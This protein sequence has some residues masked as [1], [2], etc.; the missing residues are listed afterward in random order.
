MAKQFLT[1]LNLNKNELQNIVL[2]PLATAPSSPSNGQMY[3][4]T[5]DKL[6]YVYAYDAWKAVGSVL[7][8]NGK[9]GVVVLTQDDVGDGTTYVRTHNDLT[10]ALK[11][12]YATGIASHAPAYDSTATYAKGDRCTYEGQ[13]YI[14]KDAISTAEDWTASHWTATTESAQLDLKLDLAGGTMSGAIAMGNNKI[15]GLA[16]PTADGDAANK[17]YV[18]DAFAANDAMIFKGTI[19]AAADTPTITAL[20]DTHEAG[21]TYRVVTAGTYASKTCEVGD[22]IICVKDGTTASDGD[23]TVAQTNIDGAVTGPASAVSGHVPTFNGTSGKVIQDGYAVVTSI[24]DDDTSLPTAGAVYDEVGGF[25]KV[26]TGTIST[27]ATT[28]DVTYTDGTVINAYAKMGNDE[29]VLDITY[30]AGKVTF[31]CAQ[32]PSAAVTC[33]V[34]HTARALS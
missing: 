15:T 10:D 3:Y 24:S 23:W 4:N 17:K 25:I 11:T 21:W 5:A 8:V 20:P 18:D 9:T 29:V 32:A 34:V 1:N 13:L 6:V 28:C 14:A 2:H 12:V 19:G 16:T 26:K 30:G 27:T 33:Y 31:T 7:S 22:L